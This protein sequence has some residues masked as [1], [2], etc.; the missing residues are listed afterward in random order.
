MYIP[1]IN[2][3]MTSGAERLAVRKKY[4]NIFNVEEMRMLCWTR[5]KT[6]KDSVRNQVVQE[7]AKRMPNDNIPE[8][9]NNKLDKSGE[10]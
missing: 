4:E 1:E 7:D 5:A 2:T 10:E 9:E 3:I 8:T 6:R